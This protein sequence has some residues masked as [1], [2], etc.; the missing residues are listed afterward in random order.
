MLGS[1]RTGGRGGQDLL[2]RVLGPGAR[3]Q[4][5]TKPARLVPGAATTGTTITDLGGGPADPRIDQLDRA[6]GG[7]PGAGSVALVMV[8]LMTS[9]AA[10]WPG[11]AR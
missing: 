6:R 3:H 2:R 7:Q 9:D 5:R 8:R 11:S 1:S 4:G 10:R